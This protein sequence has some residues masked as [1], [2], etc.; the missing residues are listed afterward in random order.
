MFRRISMLVLSFVIIS[1][2]AQ[3]CSLPNPFGGNKAKN[4]RI[5]GV[6][7]RDPSAK[8]DGFGTI[9]SVKTLSG[10][11]S[12]GAL[13][14]TSGLEIYQQS[15]QNLFLLTLQKGLFKTT[16][17]GRVWERVYVF[18]LSNDENQ[19]QADIAKNDSIAYYDLAINPTDNSVIYVSG[20]LNG[21]GKIFRSINSGETFKE[22]YSEVNNK[23]SV[24]H[25]AINPLDSVKVYAALDGGA[26]IR[27][28]D[29]GS[30]WQ[31]VQAFKGTPTQIG[32]IPQYDNQFFALLE[33]DGLAI[34]L[35][36]GQTWKTS[37]L[38]KIESKVGE[39]QPKEIEF[40]TD[41]FKKTDFGKYEKII[42]VPNQKTGQRGY[43]LI[44]D[45]QLW[46]TEDVTQ[47][48]RKLVLPLQGEKSNLLDAVPDPALGL[49]K[50]WVSIDNKLFSTNDRGT[51]WDVSDK[52]NIEG[53][54]GNISQILVDNTNSDVL[55]V[56]LADPKAKR[57]GGILGLGN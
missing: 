41:I 15:N 46:F 36:E 22:V 28:S 17:A 3:S 18:P 2:T 5:L 25:L 26:I 42:P 4:D 34:T 49:E 21:V 13:N 6:I 40:N 47:P 56:V 20:A 31:K 10:E 54:I 23:V 12:S 50:I 19:R 8:E 29:A 7:K 45:S 55:Y 35:D 38:Q 39:I 11:V 53:Q 1:F 57:T 14:G 32:F 52:F 33:R 27:S 16:D 51:N 43:V 24:K 37:E 9:N 44:A 48:Y 30:T